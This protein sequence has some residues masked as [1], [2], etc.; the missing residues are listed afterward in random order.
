M[1]GRLNTYLL[2]GVALL[3]RVGARLSGHG[4]ASRGFRGHGPQ[5]VLVLV[6]V[7]QQA[8][9]VLPLLGVLLLR[10]GGGGRLLL[11]G[12]LAA[13]LAEL[14]LLLRRVAGFFG[15]IDLGSRPDLGDAAVRRRRE[16]LRSRD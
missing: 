1:G 2:V 13:V 3:G 5:L 4:F 8:A 6:P 9:L 12:P 10:D 16:F 7:P 14:L 11:L 15:T